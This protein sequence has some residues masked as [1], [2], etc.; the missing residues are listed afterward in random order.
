MLYG[1]LL[2]LSDHP[3]LLLSNHLFVLKS[4]SFGLLLFTLPFWC[5][6]DFHNTRQPFVYSSVIAEKLPCDLEE[7][8]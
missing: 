7:I 1:K 2:I 6:V 3:A 8:R 4:N 5:G